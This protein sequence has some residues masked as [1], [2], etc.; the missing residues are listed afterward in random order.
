MLK[1][2]LETGCG[3]ST[4]KQQKFSYL[5]HTP[6][7][8][9]LPLAMEMYTLL[10]AGNIL[11]PPPMPHHISAQTTFPQASLL[12]PL[13]FSSLAVK[14][15]KFLCRKGL[16]TVTSVVVE[17]EVLSETCVCIASTLHLSWLYIYLEWLCRGLLETVETLRTPTPLCIKL[18]AARASMA[19]DRAKCHMVPAI[20][21]LL[22]LPL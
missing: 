4:L 8:L 16:G 2:T 17:M 18:M 9:F 5:R 19:G 1:I 14:T 21:H 11:Y 3:Q 6:C 7:G 20:E 12:W 10:S 22:Y 13:P 15:S